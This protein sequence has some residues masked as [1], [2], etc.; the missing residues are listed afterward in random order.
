MTSIHPQRLLFTLFILF[1]TTF[2]TACRDNGEN[3]DGEG[4]AFEMSGTLTIGGTEM[5]LSSWLQ[6]AFS[7]SETGQ[8]FS[9]SFA[10]NDVGS[11]T[12]FVTDLTEAQLKAKHTFNEDNEDGALLTIT[13]DGTPATGNAW[14]G[15][16]TITKIDLLSSNSVADIKLVSGSFSFS[17]T[18]VQGDAF[19]GSGSFENAQATFTN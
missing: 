19:E 15:D 2:V 12:M 5:D 7:F 10:K 1:A 17:G 8:G 6:G 9:A 16:L 13:L 18:T 3:P 14:S 11:F 4:P